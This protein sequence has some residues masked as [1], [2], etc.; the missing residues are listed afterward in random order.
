MGGA[1]CAADEVLLDLEHFTEGGGLEGLF[2]DFL[3]K[4]DLGFER[5]LLGLV[6]GEFA[7][8]SAELGGGFCGVAAFVLG[9]QAFCKFRE[10]AA[11]GGEVGIS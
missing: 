9:L 5:G 2:L 6:G 3:G 10:E 7:H 1:I 11:A 8:E 4:G